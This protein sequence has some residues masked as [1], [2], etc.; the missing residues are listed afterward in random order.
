MPAETVATL[1]FP[2]RDGADRV[3][4]KILSLAPARLVIELTFRRCAKRHQFVVEN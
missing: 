2:H 1:G 4:F 3:L